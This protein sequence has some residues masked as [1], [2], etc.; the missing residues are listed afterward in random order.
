MSITVDQIARIQQWLKGA[1]GTIKLSGQTP[2]T[3][4]KYR[5]DHA[6]KIEWLHANMPDEAKAFDKAYQKALDAA[7]ARLSTNTLLAD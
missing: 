5:A 4:G 6:D 2:Q 7:R 1:T 3:L